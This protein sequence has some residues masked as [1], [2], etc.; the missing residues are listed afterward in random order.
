MAYLGLLAGYEYVH[1]ACADPLLVRML[2]AYL[3]AE[4]TPSLR[5]VPGMDLAEYQRQVVERFANPAVRDTLARL[6]VDSS[7]RMPKFVLPV[8]REN[9]AAGRPIRIG[10]LIVAS[11]ARFAEGVDDLGRPLALVDR[12]SRELQDRAARQAGASSRFVE[13][14]DLFGDLGADRR[15]VDAYSQALD[16][17]RTLGARATM[18]RWT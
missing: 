3:S 4:A 15:F 11:W 10:A 1:E 13:L 12:R 16:S 9:L 2:S 17:L 6:A 14:R 5:P 7:D 8:I 18:E